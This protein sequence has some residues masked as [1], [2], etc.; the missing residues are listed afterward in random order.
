M[1]SN[2]ENVAGEKKHEVE[3]VATEHSAVRT[4]AGTRVARDEPSLTDAAL[5]R[6]AAARAEQVISKSRAS[7]W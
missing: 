6:S 7:R 1:S 4:R 3:V 2:G 5:T